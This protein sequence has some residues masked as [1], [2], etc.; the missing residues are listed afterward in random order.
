M[1]HQ[2]PSGATWVRF[3]II[4]ATLAAVIVLS[5]FVPFVSTVFLLGVPV[6]FSVV[7]LFDRNPERRRNETMLNE[8]R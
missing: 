6:V 3:L 5:V 1:K 8:G 2:A 4:A 7:N